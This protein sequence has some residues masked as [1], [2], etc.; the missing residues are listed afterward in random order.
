[1]KTL[2]ELLSLTEDTCDSADK[3]LDAWKDEVKKAYPDV[4]G[5]LKF[6]S[7]DQGKHISAEIDGEDR[8]Y[9]VFDVEKC[10]GEVLSEAVN[11]SAESPSTFLLVADHRDLDEDIVNQLR[12]GLKKLSIFT[13]IVPGTE[14]SDTHCIVFSKGPMTAKELKAFNKEE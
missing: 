6:K 5:K 10:K 11:N 8:C 1:M 7:K 12:K 2:R 13:Y 3:A 4:A 9:G 14:G